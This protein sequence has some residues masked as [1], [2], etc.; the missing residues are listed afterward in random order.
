MQNEFR[1]GTLAA[2]VALIFDRGGN[3]STTGED[4][5]AY[6]KLSIKSLTKGPVIIAVQLGNKIV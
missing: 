3:R 4:Y 2:A 1:S 5:L 6:K